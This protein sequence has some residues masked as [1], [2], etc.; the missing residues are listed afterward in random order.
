MHV[1]YDLFVCILTSLI[2]QLKG[3]EATEK[4]CVQPFYAIIK[5]VTSRKNTWAQWY[6]LNNSVCGRPS[7]IFKIDSLQRYGAEGG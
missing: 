1:R 6:N 5:P 7:Y 2:K 3:D 4:L